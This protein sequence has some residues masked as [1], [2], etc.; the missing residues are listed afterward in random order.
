M[1]KKVL[2][3]THDHHLRGG[4]NRSLLDLL[5]NLC[6]ESFSPFVVTPQEGE[7]TQ[8]CKETGVSYGLSFPVWWV[9][10]KGWTAV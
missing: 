3:F 7:F 10:T 8:K 6:S 5:R 2:F 9:P 1:T 4:A